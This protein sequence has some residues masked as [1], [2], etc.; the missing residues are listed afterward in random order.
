[1]PRHGAVAAL[2]VGFLLACTGAGAAA[3]QKQTR[4]DAPELNTRF[5]DRLRAE[6]KAAPDTAAE[7]A[8][9]KRP[10]RV[11]A[12]SAPAAVSR[13]R[14]AVSAEAE[15][16]EAPSKGPARSSILERRPTPPAA[17]A[18]RGVPFEGR[19]GTGLGDIFE[20]EPNDTSAQILDDLPVNVVGASDVIDDVDF[21][22]FTAT[23][24]ESIRIE[25]IADRLGTPLDS[26]VVVLAEDGETLLAENDDFFSGSG[27][28]FIRFVAP[29]AGTQLYFIG[30]SDFAG[31]GGD[32]YEYVLN[33]T[34]ARAPDLGEQESNDTT[35]LADVFPVPGMTF[36]FS[37][38][39]DDI[40]VFVFEANGGRTL[41]VD[42]DAEIFFS[43]MDPVVE[44][45]DENGGF[46]FGVDDADGLDPRFNILLPYSGTYYIAVYNA[47]AEGGNG[48]Q[49]TL[50]LSTQDG[51][52]SPRITGFK[53]INGQLLKKVLGTGFRAGARAEIDSFL[54]ASKPAP[55]KPTT[56]VKLTPARSIRR[57]D[58]VTVVNGDGRRSNPG[59]VP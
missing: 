35:G 23:Q 45:Y 27:D 59:V 18:E 34:V 57:G 33:V 1:M 4:P 26:Y 38:D 56:V 42:V 36:G 3:G 8:A 9:A 21:Y 22:A 17:K 31:L 54:V 44:L 50:N 13:R 29:F 11:K 41:V 6:G 47:Q 7:K 55:R 25:I 28:S 51:S 19:H 2:T 58:V 30:V 43:L 32:D 48:Y 10:A 5:R 53:V 37:D 12:G 46:L 16:Q 15:K 14:G 40:D 49:Y 52:D 24:G 20:D 39:P